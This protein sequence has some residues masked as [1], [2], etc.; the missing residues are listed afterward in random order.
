AMARNA[1][2]VGPAA[3]LAIGGTFMLATLF[4]GPI[5]GASMNPARS[6]GPALVSGTWTAQWIYQLGPF[7]GAIA[8]AKT[9]C[10]LRKASAPAH[11]RELAENEKALE[12]VLP[13]D[14]PMP[15]DKRYKQ[16]VHKA[17]PQY[18]DWPQTDPI[19]AITP[20]E[21]HPMRV[22]FLCTHNSA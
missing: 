21:I 20:T 13:A 14:K 11:I 1:R 17:I 7:L 19:M 22:L 6:L 10:W 4:A 18:K 12:I 2:A 3:A 15:H 9:Y 8:G 16:T 5:S